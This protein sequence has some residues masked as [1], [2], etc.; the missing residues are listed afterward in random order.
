[1]PPSWTPL[2]VTTALALSC[3]FLTASALITADEGLSTLLGS[4]LAQDFKGFDRFEENHANS[5]YVMLPSPLNP[6]ISISTI[7]LLTLYSL[8]GLLLQKERRFSKFSKPFQPV[9]FSAPKTKL[10]CIHGS[11]HYH[12]DQHGH[13]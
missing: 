3:L 2:L 10:I 7:A 6:L 4:G 8:P 11:H 13:K 5:R 12:S 9:R 1:M